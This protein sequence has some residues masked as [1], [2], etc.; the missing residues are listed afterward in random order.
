MLVHHRVPLLLLLS[1]QTMASSEN[2][3]SMATFSMA[4]WPSS[5]RSPPAS[6][7][8]STA[9]RHIASSSSTK[10][11]REVEPSFK[12]GGRARDTLASSSSLRRWNSI[13]TRPSKA[14][15]EVRALS[16][17][18]VELGTC[19]HIVE[20]LYFLSNDGDVS[21]SPA[22]SRVLCTP[23]L[24]SIREHREPALRRVPCPMAY[25]QRA[26]VRRV[27]WLGF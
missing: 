18:T 9:S 21:R 23:P 16:V 17:N 8:S 22:L 2:L 10:P 20:C 24:S 7:S 1:C 26:D 4:T 13:P 5:D 15:D 6:S 27:T 25:K 3:I 12:V 11:D 19:W 14:D